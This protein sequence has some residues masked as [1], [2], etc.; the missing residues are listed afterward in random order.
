MNLI[1]SSS[2][3]PGSPVPEIRITFPDEEDRDSGEKKSGRVVR[4]IIS[5]NGHEGLEPLQQD[6]LPAYQKEDAGKFASLDLN[7]MGGLREGSAP[8]WS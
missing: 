7:R 1:G 5:E 8:R 4:V 3:R 2:N 6:Q